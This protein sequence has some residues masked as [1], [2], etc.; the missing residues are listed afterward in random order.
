MHSI[1]VLV[2]ALFHVGN[3]L[4]FPSLNMPPLAMVDIQRSDLSQNERRD[5]MSLVQKGTENERCR[6]AVVVGRPMLAPYQRV[7]II[8]GCDGGSSGNNQ[9]FWVAVQL[10][11]GLRTLAFSAAVSQIYVLDSAA[12]GYRDIV[13]TTHEAYD[14]NDLRLIQFDGHQYR[15]ERC[16]E[17]AYKNGS[18]KPRV[19]V[20]RCSELGQFPE[21]LRN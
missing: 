15:V 8:R 14:W 3:F 2:V 6:F 21:A 12:N 17:R 10:A 16:A 19:A 18:S 1:F 13:V 4:P 7:F 11:S 9:I 5:V 20:V